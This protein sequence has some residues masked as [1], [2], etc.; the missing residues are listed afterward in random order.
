MNKNTLI[1]LSGWALVLA[2][3]GLFSVFLFFTLDENNPLMHLDKTAYADVT[4]VYG[5]I[6]SPYLLAAG[7][8]GLRA[9]YRQTIGEI[10]G[11]ILLIGAVVG[12]LMVAVGHIGSS[13]GNGDLWVLIIFGLSFSMLCLTIFGFMAIGSKPLP[14]WNGLPI[15]AGGLVPVF[16]FLDFV[17][18][19]TPEYTA[20]TDF[21][22][23]S[24]QF[25]S[26][27]ALGVVL[28]GDVEQQG[29]PLVA[30]A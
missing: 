24:L 4:Y 7:M 5:L 9:R 28:Q 17:L 19:I 29:E 30:A 14:R 20:W 13:T 8:L 18:N 21:G 22:L 3:I 2:G 15:L 27:I 23:L 16:V 1:R 25:L 12:S 26:M 11:G 6:I 10:S